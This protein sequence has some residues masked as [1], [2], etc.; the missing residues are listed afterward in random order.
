[1]A[2][3]NRGGACRFFTTECRTGNVLAK[4]EKVDAS[5]RKGMRE[6]RGFRIFTDSLHDTVGCSFTTVVFMQVPSVPLFVSQHLSSFAPMVTVLF[7]RHSTITVP[8]PR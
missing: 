7:L 2:K 6:K 5:F 8:A 3:Y 1:M 4:V